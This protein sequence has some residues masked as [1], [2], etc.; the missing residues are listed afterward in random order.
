MIAA[1]VIEDGK[2]LINHSAQVGIDRCFVIAVDATQEQA[3]TGV[4][5]AVVL[6]APVDQFQ[7][8][9]R[10]RQRMSIRP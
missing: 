10:P 1:N 8:L 4:D 7:S 2:M 9:G 5:E 6:I 3:R